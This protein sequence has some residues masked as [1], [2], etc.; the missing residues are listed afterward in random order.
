MGELDVNALIGAATLV[1]T[2][3][4]G[5]VLGVR[6]ALGAGRRLLA[7]LA[8]DVER[9]PDGAAAPRPGG[10]G[11]LLADA[12]ATRVQDRL[13]PRFERIEG[14]LAK[15]REEQEAALDREAESSRELRS[16]QLQIS[17]RLARVEGATGVAVPAAELEAE[18][19]PVHGIPLEARR[20]ATR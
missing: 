1:L 14:E 5:G 6:S 20:R 19:T 8:S 11:E 12:I 2:A 3:I 13:E 4:G 16:L 9:R 18:A 7:A 10:D 17:T 15:V